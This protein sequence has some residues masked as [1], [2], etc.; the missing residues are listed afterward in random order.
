MT[1][2]IGVG[3][4]AVPLGAG[5]DRTLTLWA[6]PSFGHYFWTTLVELAA[7]LGGGVRLDDFIGG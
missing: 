7:D 5:P 2:M 4:V 3:V 6:D 1:S